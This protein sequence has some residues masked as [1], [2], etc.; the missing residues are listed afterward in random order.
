MTHFVEYD[1]WVCRN[2][3]GK[4]IT[5]CGFN[6]KS[7]VHTGKVRRHLQYPQ[8][9]MRYTNGRRSQHHTGPEVYWRPQAWCSSVAVQGHAQSLQPQS[10]C[11]PLLPSPAG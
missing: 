4:N 9:S 7:V 11:I 3:L 1:P 6:K 2:I 5:T 8:S 10:S